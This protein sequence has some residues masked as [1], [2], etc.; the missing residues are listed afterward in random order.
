MKKKHVTMKS[1]STIW[2]EAYEAYALDGED[3]LIAYLEQTE[4]S[5]A[6]KETLKE[7][8]ILTHSL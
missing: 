5:D 1:F 6:D 3:G 4:L 8:I 2:N 7:D